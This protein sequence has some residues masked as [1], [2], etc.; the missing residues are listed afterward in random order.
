MPLC[1]FTL[2]APSALLSCLR[3][4]AL[5]ASAL[6]VAAAAQAQQ[7]LPPEV[8]AALARAKVPALSFRGI[9]LDASRNAVPRVDHLKE[10]LARLA[11]MGL[12]RFCLYTEETYAV[13]GEPLFGYARGRYELAAAAGSMPAD[14][15]ANIEADARR[16]P[17]DGV[18]RFKKGWGGYVVR[19]MPAFDRVFI[20]PAYWYWQWRRGE[21]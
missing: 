8:D 11:L 15:L 6:L 5:A 16:D 10:R 3:A 2:S 21:A 9:M 17:L 7:A 4:G 1:P 14:E 19:T 18:Y 20:A 12:N 13:P